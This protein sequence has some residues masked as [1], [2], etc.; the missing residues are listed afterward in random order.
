VLQRLV[1]NA[2]HDIRCF[3]AKAAANGNTKAIVAASRT[4]LVILHLPHFNDCFQVRCNPKLHVKQL[5][6]ILELPEMDTAAIAGALPAWAAATPT[7]V[8]R[9]LSGNSNSVAGTMP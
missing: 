1:Q 3:C 2:S 7:R 9:R 5:T 6:G 4:I 8:D